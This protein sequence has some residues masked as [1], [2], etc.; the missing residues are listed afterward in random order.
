M[1]KATWKNIKEQFTQDGHKIVPGMLGWDYNYSNALTE[2]DKVEVVEPEPYGNPAEG[3]WFVTAGRNG[4]RGT[5]DGSRLW[6]N[7]P[8]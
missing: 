5:F 1:D 8:W 2:D 4:H 7:R 3:V 6:V